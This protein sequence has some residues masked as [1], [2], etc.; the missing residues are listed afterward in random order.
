MVLR[1]TDPS[2]ECHPDKHAHTEFSAENNFLQRIPYLREVDN[3][4]LLLSTYRG[5][6]DGNE[7]VTNGTRL[8]WNS[9]WEMFI[10]K[11]LSGSSSISSI[12]RGMHDLCETSRPSDHQSNLHTSN[13]F[14]AT[15]MYPA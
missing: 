9:Q 8:Y 2:Q 4:I 12:Y 3:N 10:T 15:D 6:L 13:K 5:K 1:L 14:Q 7:L 11:Y